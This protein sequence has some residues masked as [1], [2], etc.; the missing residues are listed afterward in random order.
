[1]GEGRGGLSGGGDGG[2]H[3]VAA[4]GRAGG[5]AKRRTP[6]R[7]GGGRRGVGQAREC[8]CVEALTGLG[9]GGGAVAA[10]V[11]GECRV[12]SAAVACVPLINEWISG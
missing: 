9:S 12:V 10:C 4:L 2:S 3:A 7:P 6:C 11:L 1:V 8:V 5:R